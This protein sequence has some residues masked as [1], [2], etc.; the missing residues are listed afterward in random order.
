MIPSA[1]F[2]L[3]CPLLFIGF[4]VVAI[5]VAVRSVRAAKSAR[6]A[7]G[8]VAPPVNVPTDPGEDGFWIVSC[9]ADPGSM[10]Y[11][12]YW[13]AGTRYSGQVP[14]KPAPDGR[15]FVYTGRRPE[16]VSIVRIVQ[17]DDDD[18]GLTGATLI[19][20]IMVAGSI[21]DPSDSSSAPGS[22]PPSSS[23]SSFPSAY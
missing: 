23:S 9:P 11:Y 15:Q 21:W 14:F 12:H 7:A 19:P 13:S 5:I 4:A 8:V 3:L 18:D 20:P 22:P 1:L 10:I 17:V 2:G 6:I 16:Q